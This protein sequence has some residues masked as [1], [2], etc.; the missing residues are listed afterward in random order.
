M[1]ISECDPRWAGF[2]AAGEDTL[3]RLPT[4]VEEGLQ[5][6]GGGL[7]VHGCPRAFAAP[8]GF[9]VPGQR[10]G[11]REAFID[12][13]QFAAEFSGERGAQLAGAD[14]GLAFA[15][16]LVQWQ[17]DHQAGQLALAQ[18]CPEAGGKCVTRFGG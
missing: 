2:V 18:R 11:C 3:R 10:L 4:A 9:A 8:V 7:S 12:E 6:G 1:C 14:G 17:A 5:D 13:M 16:V 15:A